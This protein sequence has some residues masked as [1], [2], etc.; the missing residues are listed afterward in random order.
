MI[1]LHV[2]YIIDL[3][4]V[5][6]EMVS[7]KKLRFLLV[8]KGFQ[9]K[10]LRQALNLTSKTIQRLRDDDGY[11]DLVTLEKICEFFKV[12]IGDIM[13]VKLEPPILNIKKD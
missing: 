3:K 2:S 5:I 11:V 6:D 1:V 9:F 4:G 10:D 7:Y 13:E 12:D 8:E